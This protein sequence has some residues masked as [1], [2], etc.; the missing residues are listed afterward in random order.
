MAEYNLI[1]A[2]CGHGPH[3]D[4]PC[5]EVNCDCTEFVRADIHIAA[6]LTNLNNAFVT[7]IPILKQLLITQIELFSAAFPEAEA[8]VI[9]QRQAAAEARNAQ[10]MAASGPRAV[11]DVANTDSTKEISIDEF[12]AAPNF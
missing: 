8:K 12:P 1:C 7:E 6:A 10:Q 2:A 5:H 4:K 9:A 11:E 3:R